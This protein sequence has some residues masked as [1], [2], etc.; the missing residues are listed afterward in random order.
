MWYRLAW[1]AL[2]LAGALAIG[3]WLAARL[4]VLSHDACLFGRA[5]LPGLSAETRGLVGFPW[6]AA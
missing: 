6:R 4:L 3:V 2:G 1:A 5:A